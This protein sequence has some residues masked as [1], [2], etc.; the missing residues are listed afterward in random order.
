MIASKPAASSPLLSTSSSSDEDLVGSSN[1]RSRSIGLADS[2]AAK[3][4][5]QRKAMSVVKVKK[6]ARLKQAATM[7]FLAL[8]KS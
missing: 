8:G 1:R 4:L 6:A 2:G 5:L 3:T 7:G